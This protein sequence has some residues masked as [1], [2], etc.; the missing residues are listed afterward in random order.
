MSENLLWLNILTK[1]RDEG[2]IFVTAQL[3]IRQMS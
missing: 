2:I 1:A 3:E